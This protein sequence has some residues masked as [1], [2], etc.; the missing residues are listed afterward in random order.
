[1]LNYFA[2]GG[3]FQGLL[4]H[5]FIKRLRLQKFSLPLIFLATEVIPPEGRNFVNLSHPS[6]PSLVSLN[7]ASQPGPGQT[8]VLMRRVFHLTER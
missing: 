5:T 3:N 2:F 8:Q 1:M 6:L 7:H 4:I